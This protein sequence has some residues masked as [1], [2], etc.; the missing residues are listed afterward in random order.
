M[1]PENG[2]SL[3]IKQSVWNPLTPTEIRYLVINLKYVKKDILLW[4]VAANWRGDKFLKQLAELDAILQN[5]L[6]DYNTAC[7]VQVYLDTVPTDY[8]THLNRLGACA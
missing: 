3:K 8:P 6:R 5:L 1:Q 2:K 7:S 4:N